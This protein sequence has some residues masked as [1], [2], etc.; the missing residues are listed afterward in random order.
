MKNGKC[1]LILVEDQVEIVNLL[2]IFMRRAKIDIELT[3]FLDGESA[4]HFLRSLKSHLHGLVVLDLNLPR[5]NGKEVLEEL[6]NNQKVHQIPIIIF[7]GSED[8]EDRRECLEL[9]AKSF[10]VKPWSAKGYEQFVR[11]PFLDEL[12]QNCPHLQLA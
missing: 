1:R 6:K 12:K 5:L 7:T 2:S 10:H 3:H 11:G 4:L 9:G 8:P